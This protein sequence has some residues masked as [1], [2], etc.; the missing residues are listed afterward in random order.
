MASSNVHVALLRGINVGGR[1]KLRMHDLRA[2]FEELGCGDVASYIQSGNVVFTLAAAKAKTLAG[3]VSERI[4]EDFDLK[5][6]VVLR[7][8]AQVRAAF[9][10]DPFLARGSDENHLH[11]SFLA[12]RPTAARARALDPDRSPPDRFELVGRELY[13]CCPNGLARTK[14]TSDWIDRGLATVSTTRNRRTV[15]AILEL[16][17]A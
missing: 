7:K 16:A 11:I 1:N 17:D 10:A 5:V 13:L 12:D 14:L 4:R 6:P 8:A 15:A 9:D 3:R 2:L